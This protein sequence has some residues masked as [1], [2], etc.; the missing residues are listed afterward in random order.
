MK[1]STGEKILITGISGRIAFPIAQALATQRA[2][3]GSPLHQTGA[4]EAWKQLF[5]GRCK[6]IFSSSQFP[7]RDGFRRTI[8]ARYPDLVLSDESA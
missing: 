4:A 8:K 6:W 3:R 1:C 2:V 7:W 5:S